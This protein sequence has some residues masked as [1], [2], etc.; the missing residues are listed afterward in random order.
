MADDGLRRAAAVLGR[1]WSMLIVDRLRDGPARFGDLTASLPGISTN[2]LTE[3]L[4][5]LEGQGVVTRDPGSAPDY[6]I[7]Y[8]LTATGRSLAP[9]LDTLRTWGTALPRSSP[10]HVD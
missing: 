7:R 10:G 3:R 8:A 9:A 4:R 6:V 2:L 1:P 5:S